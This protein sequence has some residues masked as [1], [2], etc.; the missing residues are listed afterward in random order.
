MSYSKFTF[1][2]VRHEHQWIR[3]ELVVLVGLLHHRRHR[4]LLPRTPKGVTV[5]QV[6]VIKYPDAAGLGLP[7]ALLG[8]QRVELGHLEISTCRLRIALTGMP[9][10]LAIYKHGKYRVFPG[11]FAQN[12]DDQDAAEAL[13]L[14][15]VLFRLCAI[16]SDA[17]LEQVLRALLPKLLQRYELKVG[18]SKPKQLLVQI[19]NHL[20]RWLKPPS[21]VQLPIQDLAI[22]ITKFEAESEALR[23]SL[24]FIEIGFARAAEGGKHECLRALLKSRAKF[25]DSLPQVQRLLFAVLRELEV[26][27]DDA[28][29]GLGELDWVSHQC[30]EA[31]FALRNQPSAM[32][33]LLRTKQIPPERLLVASI[34]CATSNDQVVV[35]LGREGV[36]KSRD[37]CDSR[38]DNGKILSA[39]FELVLIEKRTAWGQ[40]VL[41]VELLTRYCK[42]LSEQLCKV[43]ISGLCAANVPVPLRIATLGLLQETSAL[44]PP[45]G[46]LD[47]LISNSLQKSQDFTSAERVAYLSC[48]VSWLRTR[49]RGQSWKARHLLAL[50]QEQ[51]L[52]EI[53]LEPVL[54]A[55]LAKLDAGEVKLV[56]SSSTVLDLAETAPKTLQSFLTEL[57]VVGSKVDLVAA[58]WILL[59]Q[60]SR[61]DAVSLV[62][63]PKF[64]LMFPFVQQRVHDA[65]PARVMRFLLS[66]LEANSELVDVFV[67]DHVKLVVDGDSATAT[68]GLACDCVVALLGI[69]NVLVEDLITWDWL[70]GNLQ[71]PNSALH[72]AASKVVG[73][74]FSPAKWQMEITNWIANSLSRFVHEPG[75]ILAVGEVPTFAEPMAV[76]LETWLLSKEFGEYTDLAFQSLTSFVTA[77]R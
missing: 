74:M 36:K 49:H 20:A 19:F 26:D 70:R 16:D 10:P 37:E 66:L 77:R 5:V 28:G 46:P 40:K 54:H 6:Y 48:L 1:L 34:L 64:D 14:E 52:S 65:F 76:A 61:T 68:Q 53:G 45:T 71:S 23:L 38:A 27:E 73:P 44:F 57:A 67:I 62:A 21:V 55:L 60:P 75:A 58:S 11:S 63:R 13:E 72:L 8:F 22:G 41:A 2:G 24:M 50:L 51:F 35:R 3:R 4:A 59:C 42:A 15:R 32:E 31:C 56:V 33:F 7:H 9:S 12:M 17:R 39:L 69:G 29:G 25:S 18:D 30:I 43:V 47:A